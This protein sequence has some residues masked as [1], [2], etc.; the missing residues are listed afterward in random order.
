M[1]S[2]AFHP[3]FEKAFSKIKDR[4]LK[5][6]IIQQLEKMRDNPEI[7]KPMR[8]NRKGPRQVYSPPFRLSHLCIPEE[9]KIIV[10]ELYH[11]DKQ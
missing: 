7:G 9:N 3:F 8:F 11:K 1:V 10:L 2:A 6:R 5:E 4:R